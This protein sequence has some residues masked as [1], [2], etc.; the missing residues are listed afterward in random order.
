MK[1]IH[2]VD[3]IEYARANC[4]QHQLMSALNDKVQHCALSSL[5]RALDLPTDLIVC[6]LK[7][8]TLYRE[9]DKIADLIGRTP[10]VVYDQDPWQA[11]MDDSPFK[12]TY[13]LA[14]S[15]LNVKS[16]AVTTEL[17]AE[18]LRNRNLPAQFVR[19]W[20]LPEY[21]NVGPSYEDR[22]VGAGFIGTVHP[23]R[24]ALFDKM[25]DMGCPINVQAGNVLGYRDYLRALQNIRVFIHSEDGPL[26]VDGGSM[27]LKDGLWIKDIEAASQGCFSIRNSGAGY[28]SYVESLPADKHGN[29]LVMHFDRPED[30]PQ[31]LEAIQKMD[32]QERQDLINRTVEHIRVSNKWQETAKSLLSE[33]DEAMDGKI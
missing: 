20:V 14:C 33:T 6:C 27:N 29:R 26:I 1:A 15:K 7:Q 23:Y 18:F 8:R 3:S 16:I 22:S 10:V 31:M 28:S 30:V 24:K 19:M 13:E 25:D 32:P 5:E 2:L 9:V 12:G 4:F 21:C 11:Y 17:W